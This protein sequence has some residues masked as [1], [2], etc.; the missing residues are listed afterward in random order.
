MPNS[1]EPLRARS[2]GLSLTVKDLPTSLKWYTEVLGFKKM[3]DFER[4]GIVTGAALMAG[5]AEISINQDDGKKGKDRALGQGF[6]FRLTT[7]QSIDAVAAR[8]K[9]GG[10]KLDSE[11]ADMPWGARIFALTDPSGYKLIVSSP[12]K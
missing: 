3:R 8:V 7:D 10:G 2:L 9:A 12:R 11:P 1:S 4:D 5:D 6:S